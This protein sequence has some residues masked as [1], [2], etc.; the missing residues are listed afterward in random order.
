[1]Q[2]TDFYGKLPEDQA[3]YVSTYGPH[4][5][6]K[7]YRWAV[8][9][10]EVRDEETGKKKKLEPW[11]PEYIDDMLKKYRIE[12]K[13]ASGYDIYYLANMFKADFYGKSLPTEEKL[14]LH[15]KLYADDIDGNPTRAF[16]EFY[17]NCIGK[18]I[19]IPW[20]QMI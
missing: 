3:S 17:G 8:S 20:R 14:C 15:L 9:K 12:V 4:F 6:E 13:N 18:G 2:R 11:N 10:M 7:L 19:I 16:D 5:S 1:M